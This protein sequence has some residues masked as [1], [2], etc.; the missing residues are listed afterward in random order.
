MVLFIPE[1]VLNQIFFNLVNC[2]EACHQ[3][4][5]DTFDSGQF[6]QIHNQNGLLPFR[7]GRPRPG[8]EALLKIIQLTN[9]SVENLLST[10]GACG[11]V[12]RSWYF[13]N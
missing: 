7:Q 12:P 6:S 9:V 10:D 11:L 3:V 4:Y 5:T 13:R 8:L 1:K 2:N